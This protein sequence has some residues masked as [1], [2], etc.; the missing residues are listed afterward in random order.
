MK[1]LSVICFK[2]V[3][4][5]LVL[6]G[7]FCEAP[8]F[9]ADNIRYPAVAGAFYPSDKTVLAEMIDGFLGKA[10]LKETKGEILGF[11]LPHA[12]YVYSGQ[13]AA[14]GYKLASNLHPGTVILIGPYHQ[15]LIYGA[16]I[17]K[18][19]YW[20]TP[21]GN[22]AV[23]AELAGVILKEDEQR[24]GFSQEVH[25]KEHSLEVQLPF[26]QKTLGSFKILPILINDPSL[27]NTRAL[28]RAIV[29]HLNDKKILIIA[30]SDMSHYHS[31][32]TARRM[33]SLTLDLIAKKDSEGFLRELRDGNSELCGHAAVLTMLEISRLLG[34]TKVEIL[35]YSTSGDVTGDKSSVVGYSASVIYRTSSPSVFVGDHPDD[36]RRKESGNDVSK[37]GETQK[38]KLLTIARKTLESFVGKKEIPDFQETDAVLNKNGA[39]FVTLKEHGELRGCIG[40][41]AARE[42]LYLAVRNMTVE[43]ASADPRF[44]PVTSNEIKD[45]DIEI[46]VLSV[47][48]K[49]ENANRVVM[50]RHG[51]M[52][53]QSGRSGVFLPKVAG[54]TGWTKD[55]FLNKLCSEKA[56]LLPDC[57]ED[58]RTEL[59]T[60]TTE[61]FSENQS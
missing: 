35:N 30:S 13:T 48:Q 50:G 40:S 22:A 51:V 7:V 43:A 3:L 12:G 28:A 25:L 10:P 19:G 54:E 26:L 44:S 53:R 55:Q 38:R 20:R 5:F 8:V 34:D 15:A 45:I 24:F 61:D 1:K 39:A 32:E 2:S 21:L 57:W 36:S 23:D 49:I 11:I 31:D 56:G 17:W 41:L 4:G 33:D 59:Y 37:L 52:V 14:V 9:A 42:L 18:S 29:K 46:S 60:F 16:S 58:K 47:P 6:S 27:E